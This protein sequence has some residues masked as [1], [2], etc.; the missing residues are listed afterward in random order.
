MENKN[1]ATEPEKIELPLEEVKAEEKLG[2]SKEE[3]KGQGWSKDEIEKAEKRGMV[4]EVSN[5]KKPTIKEESKVEEE[6]KPEVTLNGKLPDFT[7]NP[8]QEE[9][10]AKIFGVGTAPRAMYFRMKN[11]RKARQLAEQKALELE[12]KLKNPEKVQAVKEKELDDFGNEVD[13]EDTPLTL[14]ALKKLR[15]EEAEEIKKQQAEQGERTQAVKTAQVEQEN[16]TRTLFPEGEFDRTVELATEVL[17]NIDLIQEP[18]KQAKAV[19]L[20]RELRFAAANADKYGLDDYHGAM[21]VYEI[22]QLHPQYGK[23]KPTKT[24]TEQDQSPNNGKKLTPEQMK[25]IAENTQRRGSSA[26][27]PN[28]GGSRSV[29]AEEVTLSD[30]NKFDYKKRSWFKEKHPQEYARLQRG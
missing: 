28:G 18:W 2:P 9:A 19:R 12:Q 8:E 17:T 10:F 5:E 25:R 13:P 26:S 15:D 14:K 3:L 11:E 27:I 29:T 23:A 6:K 7:L 16:Y 22:G 1:T 30:F 4:G 21:L 20:H 24:G